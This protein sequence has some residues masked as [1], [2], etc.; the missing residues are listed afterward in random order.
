MSW[1]TATAGF[2]I[3]VDWEWHKTEIPKGHSMP[4][5][6]ALSTA[7]E[8]MVLR[9]A[10]PTWVLSLTERGRQ[11]LC[12]HNEMEVGH[13]STCHPLPALITWLQNYMIEMIE[14]RKGSAVLEDRR[15]LL[16]NLIRASM[17]DSISQ[18]DVTHRDLLGNIFVF[19]LAGKLSRLR[20]LQFFTLNCG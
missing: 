7:I 13:L 10:L 20:S 9:A 17:E 6:Q 2:G 15:D 12:G 18:K 3:N 5:M 14:D 1:L 11:V 19:M 8:G 16:S 4:F